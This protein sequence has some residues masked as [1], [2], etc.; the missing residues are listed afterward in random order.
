MATATTPTGAAPRT[1]ARANRAAA[2]LDPVQRFGAI[3]NALAAA[4]Y[5]VR[6]P[7]AGHA[8]QGANL[9]AA[10][11]R[12]NRALTLLKAASAAHAAAATPGNDGRP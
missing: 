10:V 8:E 12:A 5:F 4:L 3:Q 2:P 9:W 6:Q 1:L 7:C 11:A